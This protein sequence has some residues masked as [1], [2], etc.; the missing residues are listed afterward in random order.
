MAFK[1]ILNKMGEKG[2]ERKAVLHQMSEE[3]RLSKIAQDRQ[4][5]SNERELERYLDEDR[6]EMIKS[7]L[8]VARKKRDNDIRFNHNPL[9]TPNITNHTQWEVLK[10]KNQFSNNNNM[11]IGQESVLKNNKNLMKN[12]KKLMR[13]GNMFKI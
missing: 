12:N 13:G 10:E 5:S 8:E 4:K 11:F 3:L 6:E 1:D 7:R 9:D 2:R